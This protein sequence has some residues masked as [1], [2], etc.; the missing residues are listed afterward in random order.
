MPEQ[1]LEHLDSSLRTEVGQ[2]SANYASNNFNQQKNQ[3]DTNIQSNRNG[4]RGRGRNYIA[5]GRGR[6]HCQVCNKPGH[7]ALKCYHRFDQ[8]FQGPPQQQNQ[9]FQGFQAPPQ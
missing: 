4:Q 9:G 2:V 6:I 5:G 7:S 8:G 1:R 3:R